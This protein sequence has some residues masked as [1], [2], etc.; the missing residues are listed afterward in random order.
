MG[1]E[2][3]EPGRLYL[4]TVGAASKS[5]GCGPYGVI[6][7]CL[8]RQLLAVGERVRVV[9]EAEQVADWPDAVEMIVGSVTRP[10]EIWDAFTGVD[11]VFLTGADPATVDDAL[12]LA[13]TAHVGQIALLSSYGMGYE[14]PGAEWLAIEEAVERSGIGWTHI[15]ASA[16][17]GAVLEDT[18]PATGSDW[19]D[20]IRA[21]GVVREAFAE[22]GHYPFIHEEDLAT[23]AAAALRSDDY[24]GMT[25]DAVGVPVSTRARVR[26]IANAIGREIDSLELT[27]EESRAVWRRRGW[28]DRAIDA[29]LRTL[30]QCDPDEELAPTL[31]QDPSVADILGRAPLTFAEW[32]LEHAKFFR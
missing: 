8:A 32:A 28:P 22:T 16:V 23:V 10:L 27:P 25:V 20:T 17:M 4:L 15:R 9:A 26:F 12:A 5:E 7:R 2:I 31:D 30:E 11:A 3:F 19:A 21:E 13:R 1:P 18:Y 6:A 14:E 29:T 24:L